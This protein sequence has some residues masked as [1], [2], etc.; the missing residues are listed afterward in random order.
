MS[1]DLY[2]TITNRMIMEME[3]SLIPWNKPWMASGIIPRASYIACSTKCC[4][5]SRVNGYPSASDSRKAAMCVKG[6]RLRWWSFH[7][8][9]HFPCWRTAGLLK[10]TA[11][12]RLQ[13]KEKASDQFRYL[14]SAHCEL[15]SP[16][17]YG[18][19]PWPSSA[20]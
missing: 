14:D 16:L 11:V 15:C 12:K 10:K 20:H 4:W 2:Q 7:M 19:V 9:V 18:C 8:T 17:P 5:A 6:K 1:M 3:Q 13:T